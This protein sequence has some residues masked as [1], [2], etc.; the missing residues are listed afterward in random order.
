MCKCL[1]ISRWIDECIYEGRYED[2][3]KRKEDINKTMALWLKKKVKI[4]IINH[5]NGEKR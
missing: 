5:E 1:R 3:K 4:N 2:G